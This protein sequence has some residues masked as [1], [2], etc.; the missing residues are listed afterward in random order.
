MEKDKSAMVRTRAASALGRL[1]DGRARPA[2]AKAARS[3][4]ANLVWA[5]KN[6][7]GKLK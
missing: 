3:E 4:D 1:G 5:A 2:L 7:L 6:S